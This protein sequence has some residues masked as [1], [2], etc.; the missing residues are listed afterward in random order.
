MGL[1]GLPDQIVEA[2]VLHHSPNRSL[3][4]GF[5]PLTAVHAANSLAQPDCAAGRLERTEVLDVD[6]LARLNLKDRFL[7]WE[8]VCGKLI[9]QGAMNA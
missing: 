6:Y 4:T 8:D 9:G 5:T 2:I 3:A 1:W 7:R